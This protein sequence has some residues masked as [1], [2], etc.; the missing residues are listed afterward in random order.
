MPEP[1]SLLVMD[2]LA[3]NLGRVN[4]RATT[5]TDDCINAFIID[6]KIS[7]LI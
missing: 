5:N 4:W 7:S 2:S 3:D 1:F 6:D